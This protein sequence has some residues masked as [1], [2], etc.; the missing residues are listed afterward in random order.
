MRSI[1]LS[2][3]VLALFSCS[4]EKEQTLPTIQTNPVTDIT[5]ITAVSGG[6]VT[7][8]GGAVL[9][10]IGIVWHT[11]PGP[12]LSNSSTVEG[13]GQGNFTSQM[14]SL[15]PN[16]TYYVRAYATNNVGTNYGNEVSFK[17]N[18]DPMEISL[19]NDLLLY[20]PFT[21]NS[22]DASGKNNHGTIE[23]AILTSDRLGNASAAY[24][25]GA[26]KT[27]RILTPAE[28]LNLTGSFSISSWF[29]AETLPASANA[30]MLLS[31][32]TGDSGNDGWSYGIWNPN[33]NVNT[34]I[35]NFQANDQFNTN[36]YPPAAG[37]IQAGVWYHFV[38][39]YNK[40]TNELKYYLNKNN[41]FTKTLEF[42]TLANAK[43]VTLGYQAS[44]SGAYVSYFNGTIDEVR[45]Y[46]R[47]LSNEEVAYL[48]K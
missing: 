15:I 29:K 45:V 11:Q 21:G 30:S 12:T 3:F 27:I 39:T 25:F 38:V 6:N 40:S 46:N 23:G 4:K 16:T 22:Q 5:H 44:T 9:S 47:V 24:Q 10:A 26:N 19:R 34:Q 7:N 43:A 1:L 18:E 36:T 31:K 14:A 37:I 33:N 35:I 13:A 42:K 2:L 41:V 20:L 32:H 28:E 48:G 8:N 17:T